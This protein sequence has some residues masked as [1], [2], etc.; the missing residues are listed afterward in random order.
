[1]ITL[2]AYIRTGVE[3]RIA[4]P[5]HK[6]LSSLSQREAAFLQGSAWMDPLTGKERIPLADSGAFIQVSIREDQ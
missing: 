2:H 4:Y 6:K 1:M 5:K 3:T